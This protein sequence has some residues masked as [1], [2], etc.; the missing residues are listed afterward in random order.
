MTFLPS[1]PSMHSF[2]A[3]P[4][5]L[6]GNLVIKLGGVLCKPIHTLRIYTYVYWA[7]RAEH[8]QWLNFGIII[9]T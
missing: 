4:L 6:E 8:R 1:K 2:H 7:S 3:S 5:L 9:I